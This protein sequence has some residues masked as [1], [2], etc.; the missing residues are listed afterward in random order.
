MESADSKI[1]LDEMCETIGKICDLALPKKEQGNLEIYGFFCDLV[2]YKLGDGPL[3]RRT[4]DLSRILY[5]LDLV[6]MLKEYACSGDND[7]E[8]Q[9]YHEVIARAINNG[10]ASI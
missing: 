5:A 3:G 7:S 6:S 4:G 2:K 10:L 1:A 9:E 8:I